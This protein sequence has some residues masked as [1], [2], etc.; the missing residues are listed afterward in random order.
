MEPST[1]ARSFALVPGRDLDI[2]MT[3]H[4]NKA[5]HYMLKIEEEGVSTELGRLGEMQ[6]HEL[7][8]RG[9]AVSPN[10]GIFA[11]HSFDSL[12]VWS[13]DLFSANQKGEF[14]I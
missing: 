4:N 10:D 5:I 1:K 8:I 2:I 11:T 6:S 14:T 12:K 13:V 3:F 9:V 7:A